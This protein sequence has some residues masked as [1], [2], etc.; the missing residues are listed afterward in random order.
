M[1]PVEHRILALLSAAEPGRWIDEA[2]IF[3][4]L[5]SRGRK[6]IHVHICMIRKALGRHAIESRDGR[7]SGALPGYRL[8]ESGREAAAVLATGSRA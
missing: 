3:G 4:L 2:A 1:K 5:Q 8:S 6:A 7:R